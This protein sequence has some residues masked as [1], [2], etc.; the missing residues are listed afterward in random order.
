MSYTIVHI[1]CWVHAQ[2]K[3]IEAREIIN[4]ISELFQNEISFRALGLKPFEIADRCKRRLMP[5]QKR[6]HVKVVLMSTDIKLMTNEYMKKAITYMINQWKSLVSYISAG[7]VEISNNHCE[8]RMK[9]V[10]LNM[11]NCQNIGNEKAAEN[12]A[13]MFSLTESCTLNGIN[14]ESY[15]EEVTIIKKGKNVDKVALLPC[16]YNK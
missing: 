10:K 9:A 13:F 6:I 1:D 15:L 12:A 3:W 14:P 7:L 8:Q 2:R 16:Y 11:K 4:M 5:L